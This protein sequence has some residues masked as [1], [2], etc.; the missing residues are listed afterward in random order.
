M[1]LACGLAESVPGRGRAGSL[2]RLVVDS[3]AP[4]QDVGV[5]HSAPVV[6]T[7]PLSRRRFVAVTAGVTAVAATAGSCSLPATIGDPDPLTELAEAAHRDTVQFAAAD[8]SHGDQVRALHRLAE[9]RRVHAD[10]LDLLATPL[11]GELT[12]STEESVDAQIICPPL[13]EVLSRL[14]G[15]ASR[16]A[17][18]AVVVE[19]PRAELAASVSAACTAAVE[20]VLA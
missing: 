18:V 19:G 9:V 12:P 20:V 16:A 2:Y 13:A 3:P 5:P 1:L 14:R 15:D 4:W 10:R 7:R 6:L 8:A 11:P 17:E